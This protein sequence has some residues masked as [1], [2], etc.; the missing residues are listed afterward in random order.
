MTYRLADVAR[1]WAGFA[2]LGAGL[3]HAAVISEHWKAWWA[4]GVFFAVVAAFQLVSAMLLLRGELRRVEQSVLVVNVVVLAVWVLTR[5]TG[6]PFGPE[7]GRVEHTGAAD[8][9]AAAL[10]L[11]CVACVGML[12]SLERRRAHRSAV[13]YLAALGAGAPAMSLV[14]TPALAGTPAGEHVVPHG[15]TGSS[16][17]H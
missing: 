1:C 5:T 16:T 11:A 15:H 14:A 6:L 10:Q 12:P 8:L 9:G 3:V 7:A 4:Y 13:G 2:S 17:S